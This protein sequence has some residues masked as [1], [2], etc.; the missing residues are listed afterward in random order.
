MS[1]VVFG[2]VLA[3]K[4]LHGPAERSCYRLGRSMQQSGLGAPQVLLLSSPPGDWV[5]AV[6]G[7]GP[8]AG[9]GLVLSPPR[10]DVLWQ[11]RIPQPRVTRRVDV[12][13]GATPTARDRRL[14]PGPWIVSP[15]L[16]GWCARTELG[17]IHAQGVDSGPQSG[18]ATQFARP[19]KHITSPR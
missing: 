16:L 10:V 18:P 8:C 9:G 14:R 13:H 19:T 1:P 2:L 15:C 12:G 11:G 6:S 7:C 5:G 4:T 17:L 3:M